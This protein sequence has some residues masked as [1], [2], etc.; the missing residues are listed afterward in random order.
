MSGVAGPKMVF[1]LSRF[2]EVRMHALVPGAAMVG[3]SLVRH[4]VAMIRVTLLLPSA[5]LEDDAAAAAVAKSGVRL[6]HIGFGVRRVPVV[7]LDLC[8]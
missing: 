1:G 8:D 2:G 3:V 5:D 7:C 4:A 6:Q